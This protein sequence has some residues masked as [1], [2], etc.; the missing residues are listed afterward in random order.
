M[1]AVRRLLENALDMT[2]EPRV[3]EDIEAALELL[4]AKAKA[5]GTRLAGAVETD[6]GE[7]SESA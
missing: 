5:D 3:R 7:N 6:G 4:D 1:D 2:D